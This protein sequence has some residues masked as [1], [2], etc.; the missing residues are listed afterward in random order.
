MHPPADG[1]AHKESWLPLLGALQ[2]PDACVPIYPLAPVCVCVCV[3]MRAHVSVPISFLKWNK[4]FW[5]CSGDSF[6]ISTF[7]YTWSFG[8]RP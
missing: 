1:Q 8:A 7:D 5:M 3:H 2:K 4:C 6:S